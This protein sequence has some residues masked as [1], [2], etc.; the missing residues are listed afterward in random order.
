MSDRVLLEVKNGIAKV[1][2][3]RPDKC[4]ALD[5]ALFKAIVQVQKKI[6]TRRDIRAV[7]LTGVGKD[8][9]SGI[10]VKA[11]MGSAGT[12]AKLLFKWTPWSPNLAQ[13]VSTGWR[14]LK[15]PVIASIEGRCWGGGMQVALGVDFRIAHPESSLAVME[16]RWGLIPDMGGT[17]ALREQ[18]P[19]DKALML[20]MLAEPITAKEALEMNL[21]T[22][23]SDAPY[24]R[25]EALAKALIERSP[26]ALAEVKKLYKNRGFGTNGGVLFGETWGQ[27]KAMASKNQRVAVARQRGKDKAYHL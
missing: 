10:D 15:V 23:V 1:S 7:I 26:N 8:F 4:N 17:L 6:K 3:N 11:L 24:E 20:S 12:A 14:D 13:R 21:V 16:G 27:I 9:C 19:Q 18:L 25:A 5:Y 2:L 22:E